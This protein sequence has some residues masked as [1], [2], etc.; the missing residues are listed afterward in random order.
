MGM[1]CWINKK[2]GIFACMIIIVASMA[3]SWYDIQKYDVQPSPL[4]QPWTEN[5]YYSWINRA[6]VYYIGCAV[7][8]LTLKNPST[9]PKKEEEKVDI[10]APNESAAK[11]KL[12]LGYD[13]LPKNSGH[14]KKSKVERRNKMQK[15]V[16]IIGIISFAVI[17]ASFI[18]MFKYFQLG[19]DTHQNHQIYNTI[20]LVFGKIIF[21]IALFACLINMCLVFQKFPKAI[22]N[23]TTIQ[24][25]GNVSFC[26]YG[27][28]YNFL[29]WSIGG[30]ES[31]L[32]YTDYMYM[33]AFF[34]VFF[35]GF[36]AATW[37]ALSIEFP[38]GD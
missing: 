8:I 32:P 11:E 24:L 37:T 25:I 19:Y 2:V 31:F 34:W 18:L 20:W 21:T 17:A 12:K 10:V 5:Y 13:I 16:Y 28:H 35:T 1:L 27:W 33:G 38:L 36:L 26:L 29:Y 3:H 6:C 30:S 4:D 14:S 22:A 23:N 9:K 15:K 7:G